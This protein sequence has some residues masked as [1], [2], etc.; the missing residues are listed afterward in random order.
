MQHA[1]TLSFRFHHLASL[2]CTSDFGRQVLSTLYLK[3][4]WAN[5]L[6]LHKVTQKY[7][8]Y[9]K[10]SC[11]NESISKLAKNMSSR[12][13]ELQHYRFQKQ[14]S[15]T[16]FF[17]RKK[18]QHAWVNNLCPV[19]PNHHPRKT[20]WCSEYEAKFRVSAQTHTREKYLAMLVQTIVVERTRV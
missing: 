16:R 8:R 19:S 11:S 6:A 7:T 5:T 14:V 1:M 2:S 13:C 4:F 9:L 10:R 20:V 18:L 17:C 12:I 3:D 15:R